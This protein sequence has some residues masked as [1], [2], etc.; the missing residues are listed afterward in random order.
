MRTYI[1]IERRGRY[2]RAD[3][4]HLGVNRQFIRAH[5]DRAK[6][7][8]TEEEAFDAGRN[9]LNRAPGSSIV[10]MMRLEG[11]INQEASR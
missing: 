4:R 8:K 6:R 1:A 10:V 7:F 9:A 3:D 2:A 11:A 5:G